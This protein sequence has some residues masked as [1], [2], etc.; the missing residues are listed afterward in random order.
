MGNHDDVMGTGLLDHFDKFQVWRIFKDEKF[1][2]THI[3]INPY[4]FRHKVIC[5]VHGHLHTK[6]ISGPYLNIC[7]EKLNYT[8]IHI[9]EIVDK[10][11]Q[12]R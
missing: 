12:F 4:N 8:P 10:I 1:V 6:E 11:K 2:L 9:E 5:N 3:P 7:V